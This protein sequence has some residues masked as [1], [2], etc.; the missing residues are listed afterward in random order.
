MEGFNIWAVLAA[1]VS[2]FLLGGL[3]YSK[4]LFLEPWAKA[5]G[6]DIDAKQDSH[7]AKVFGVSFLFALIA[8]AVFAVVL[9][10]KPPLDFALGRAL[11]VGGGFVA[12]C[13]GI[14]YQF[15]NK[16]AALWL[17]DGGYHVGQFL[18]YGLILGLWH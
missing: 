7:P 3:W 5:A 12:A 10:P 2:A 1:A 13:F 17:I 4:L 8:A 15:A 16:P 14:N 6:I 9:G 18:L 11:M